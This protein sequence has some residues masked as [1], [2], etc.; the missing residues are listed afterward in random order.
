MKENIDKLEFKKKNW[1]LFKRHYKQDE[2]TSHKAE[3]IFIKHK[4]FVSRM[5][6]TLETQW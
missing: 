4:G 3:K 6:K 5:Y 1:K 2:K